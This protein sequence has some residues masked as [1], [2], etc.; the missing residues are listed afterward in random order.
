MK[1]L[2]VRARLVIWFSALLLAIIAITLAIMLAISNSALSTDVKEGLLQTVIS[3]SEEIEFLSEIT[4]SEHEIGDHFVEYKNGFLEIDDDFLNEI[5]GIHCALYDSDSNLLYGERIIKSPITTDN[6]IHAVKAGSERYYS[7]CLML[8]QGNL[9]GLILQGVVNENARKTLLSRILNISLLILPILAVIAIIGGYISAGRS[10]KPI[11]EM[12]E[13]AASIT[14]GED[15]SNRIN[16]GAGNDELHQLANTFNKMFERLETSFEDEKQFTADISHELRTPVSAILAQAQLSLEKE[17][18]GE[19]YRNALQLIERQSIRMKNIVED[20]LRFSRLER[21]E[22]LDAA[23]ETELSFLTLAVC[24]EQSARKENGISLKIEIEEDIN[25]LAD[26]DMMIRLINNLI[27]NAYRYGK[28]NGHIYVT[29]KKQDNKAYLEVAD[30]GIGID[31]KDIKR[32]FERFYQSDKSRIVKGNTFSIGLGLA[33][34]KKIAQ[35]HGG[36]VSVKS[37]VGK[38]SKF[39]V[40]LPIYD[41][42]KEEGA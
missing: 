26:T 16:I 14:D 21:L 12:N 40:V 1:R 7:Y 22:K 19:E 37:T 36:S 15:L 39:T 20:M 23:Q 3:N 32:I 38:G 35:L 10:L 33:T 24:E 17:R 25:I 29:L 42:E 30:D 13:A 41:D 9:S 5:D 28:E 11:K 27:S 31:E 4:A 8:D 18:T 6:K 34:V 2:S